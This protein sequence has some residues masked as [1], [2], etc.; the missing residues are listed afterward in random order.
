MLRKRNM[1]VHFFA[2]LAFLA[3]VVGFYGDAG[4]QGKSFLWE[5]R[6]A[7]TTVYL[8]G[9]IHFLKKESYPLNQVIEQAFSNTQKLVLEIDLGA[10]D[11]QK[12]QHSMVLKGMAADART[13]RERVSTET[14]ELTERRAEELGMK[15]Q[16]LS[17]FKPW[18]VAL[19]ISTLKLQKLGFDPNYGVDRYF[20][21]RAKK[22]KKEIVG[23]ETFEYQIDLFDRM[24]PEGQEMLLLQ[25]LK[26]LD[27]M[28]KELDRLVQSW[29]SGDSQ[30]LET[31]L[32]KSY[33]EYPE[34]YQSL[35]Y[36][37]N[38]KWLPRI[39]RFLSQT[40]STLVV[41][42]AGHLVGD[43]GLIDLLK[44]RGYAV[45]QL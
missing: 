2:G 11:Q 6:S 7:K 30:A 24:S 17:R 26:D 14:F 20:A 39:E 10:V 33:R 42:G 27:M 19:A 45:E 23:L 21:E 15:I 40:E 8:L 22:D 35:I 41:V 29:Q 4:A 1:A 44:E 9:S 5:I 38:R 13:L 16:T 28:E 18:F 36:D 43:G 25:T 32:L 31:L 12:S 3:A 34:V 37:R